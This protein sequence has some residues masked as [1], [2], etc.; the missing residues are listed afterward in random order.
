MNTTIQRT[1]HNAHVLAERRLPAWSIAPWFAFVLLPCLCAGQ[2]TVFPE[3]NESSPSRARCFSWINNAW[4]G[5]TEA[6]TLINLN[7]F[8]WLRDEY[9]MQLDCHALDAGN[10]D[11]Q[12]VQEAVFHRLR[13]EARDAA[14]TLGKI[15][16]LMAP[17][18]PWPP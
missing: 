6:Q 4:E 12:G 18:W 15:L 11:T 14:A 2:D 8:Q 7:F 3:A 5:S 1:E 10:L 13:A 16:L 9:G 17:T